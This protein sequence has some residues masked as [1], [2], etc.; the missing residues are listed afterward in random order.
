MNESTFEQA[1]KIGMAPVAERPLLDAKIEARLSRLRSSAKTKKWSATLGV[2]AAVVAMSVFLFPRAEAQPTF[3]Q[4][5]GALDDVSSVRTESFSILEDGSRTSQGTIDYHEGRWRLTT[6]GEDSVWFEGGLYMLDASAGR[7]V[8]SS[9]P[10]GPF[11]FNTKG[12]GLSSMLSSG[13]MNSKEVTLTDGKFRGADVKIATVDSTGL[14]ERM[15]IYADAKTL[16]PISVEHYSNEQDVWRL[17]GEMT[18]DYSPN[19]PQGHFA[20]RPG[21]PVVTEDDD[22]SDLFRE[23]TTPELAMIDIK[24]GRLVVRSVDVARDGTVFVTYQVGDKTRS[25][26]GFRLTVTDDLGTLYAPST[27]LMSFDDDLMQR[28]SDG[29]IEREVLVPLAPDKRWRPRT[30]KLSMRF[31]DERE[32]VLFNDS[33]GRRNDGSEW[34]TTHPNTRGVDPKALPT[35][36]EIWSG[37]FDQPTCEWRPEI[38][39]QIEYPQFAHEMKAQIF[40]AATLSRYFQNAEDWRQAERWI[41]ENLRL[42][43]KHEEQGLGP[44]SLDS[45]L[46]E[47]KAVQKRLGRGRPDATD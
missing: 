4:I 27:S 15:L 32:P 7:Y 28:S 1:L 22:K 25:W 45:A 8:H 39:A 21:V 18:F 40:R 14:R 2:A 47:L 33:I 19:F 30:V 12:L 10:S 37:A 31:T 20:L 46:K 34:F 41:K 23:L 5:A 43:R 44:Y 11:S 29:R 16:L 38:F 13:G 35:L 42:M 26:R 3:A 9:M 17:R 24:G 6:G 36:E